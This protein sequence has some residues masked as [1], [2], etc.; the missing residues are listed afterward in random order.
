MF[1]SFRLEINKASWIHLS[2]YSHGG[3]LWDFDPNILEVLQQVYLFNQNQKVSFHVLPKQLGTFTFYQRRP[4]NLVR[5]SEC[6][7]EIVETL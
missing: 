7:I 5:I 4:W 6:E 2:N 1:E 3:Y